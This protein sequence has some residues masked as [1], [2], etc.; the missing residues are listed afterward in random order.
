MRLLLSLLVLVINVPAINAMKPNDAEPDYAVFQDL[1]KEKATQEAHAMAES[2]FARNVFRVFVA[3]MRRQQDAYDNYLKQKYGV[4]VTSVAGCV[5]TD[6]IIG[7]I[8]GYNSTMKPL[9]NKKFRHDIFKEA[10]EAA[11]K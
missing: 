5:V 11:R 3:G 8:E 4:V 6:G 2:D 10:E 9:L 1:S 7:G